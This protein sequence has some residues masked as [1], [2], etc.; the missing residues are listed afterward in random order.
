MARVTELFINLKLRAEMGSA[1]KGEAID[2]KSSYQNNFHRQNKPIIP[3]CISAER[4]AMNLCSSTAIN[5][6]KL[7]NQ[8]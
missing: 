4:N 3:L 1:E 7:I 8:K 2:T 5:D 6:L